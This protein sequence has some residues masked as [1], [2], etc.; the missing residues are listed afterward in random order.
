M[1]KIAYGIGGLGDDRNRGAVDRKRGR[2]EAG[3]D[4]GRQRRRHDAPPQAP[5]YVHAP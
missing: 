4:E 5:P 3:H 1:K 2:Y